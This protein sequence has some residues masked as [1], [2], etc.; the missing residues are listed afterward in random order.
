MFLFQ[1]RLLTRIMS[2]HT[3]STL[4]SVYNTYVKQNINGDV[5][6]AS[7]PAP[8][9]GLRRGVLE[10]AVAQRP[11]ARHVFDVDELEFFAQPP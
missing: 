7:F 1:G 8:D 2:R 9:R 5:N 6:A 4:Q 11:H 10:R 3:A